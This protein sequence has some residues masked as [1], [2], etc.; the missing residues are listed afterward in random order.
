MLRHAAA[1]ASSRDPLNRTSVA[2]L[3]NATARTCAGCTFEID[4]AI[5]GVTPALSARR[6]P[7]HRRLS[8][9]EKPTASPQRSPETR[10]QVSRL[11]RRCDLFDWT[12]SR[13]CLRISANA[14]AMSQCAALTFCGRFSRT[15][16][17]IA[18]RRCAVLWAGPRRR[19]GIRA[20]IPA[21]IGRF[22]RRASGSETSTPVASVLRA[23]G[24][25]QRLRYDL[26]EPH[27]ISLAR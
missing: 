8:E 12:S 20:P 5:R 27:E 22:T 14:A 17:S 25:I 7:L 19:D 2:L 23:R 16:P 18:V 3:I 1:I 26:T 15:R 4:R 10:K 11:F 6:R 21:G 13:I 24:S 9:S